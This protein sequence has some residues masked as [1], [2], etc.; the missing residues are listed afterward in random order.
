[1]RDDAPDLRGLG[2]PPSGEVSEEAKEAM[3]KAADAVIELPG[4]AIVSV[5][6][7]ADPGVPGAKVLSGLPGIA[8]ATVV[9]TAEPGTPGSNVGVVSRS[10]GGTTLDD[11]AGSLFGA[12]EDAR[13]R[14]KKERTKP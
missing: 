14:A 9:I 4:V 5:V 2:F 3:T 1:L 10:S 7:V 12:A 13:I 8:I 6:V 11:V